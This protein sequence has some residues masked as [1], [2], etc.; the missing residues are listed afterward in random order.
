MD[1]QIVVDLALD[2]DIGKPVFNAIFD[3]DLNFPK[4]DKKF[5]MEGDRTFTQNVKQWYFQATFYYLTAS[6]F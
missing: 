5:V 4:T 2:T 3:L 1:G 6:Y